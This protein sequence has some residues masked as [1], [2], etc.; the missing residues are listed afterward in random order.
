[1]LWGTFALLGTFAITVKA[2]L[3]ECVDLSLPPAA[4]AHLRSPTG[5]SE[6][7]YSN[8]KST[9]V[10]TSPSPPPP[11][12]HFPAHPAEKCLTAS[13]NADGAPIILSTCTGEANQKWTFTNS[14]G[15][16]VVFGNKCLDV[17]EGVNADGTKLHLWTCTAN[18]QNQNWYYSKWD[19]TLGWTG[20]GKCV[21]VEAG[22]Q[23]D[24]TLVRSFHRAEER[25]KR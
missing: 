24:G 20:T 3:P 23:T 10:R 12:S 6:N 11:D 15:N 7:F 9:T 19:N 18:N 16:V 4:S 17:K 21:D 25:T 2:Q 8:P 14:S 13:S 1:M 22:G 5:S